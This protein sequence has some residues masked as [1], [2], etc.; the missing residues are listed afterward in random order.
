LILSCLTDPNEAGSQEVVIEGEDASTGE[1]SVDG[2]D[3]PVFDAGGLTAIQSWKP[4][5]S[6]QEFKSAA[7]C[8]DI[9]NDVYGVAAIFRNTTQYVL[10]YFRV[11]GNSL[12]TS[13]YG[14]KISSRVL[15]SNATGIYNVDCTQDGQDKIFITWD[16]HG[17]NSTVIDAWSC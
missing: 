4:S 16:V 5:T 13:T 9:T 3:G 10:Y 12:H 6:T 2:I 17:L 11:D 7:V 15:E 1:E 14:K 8:H